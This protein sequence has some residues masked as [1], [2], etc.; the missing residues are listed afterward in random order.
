[1]GVTKDE[2]TIDDYNQ[3]FCGIITGGYRQNDISFKKTDDDS[4][5]LDIHKE[6]LFFKM[7]CTV[8][9]LV[10]H[11][12]NYN[13]NEYGTYLLH[14]NFPYTDDLISGIDGN[15]IYGVY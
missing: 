11:D 4:E 10:G 8:Y 12:L 13:K 15:E 6:S 1:M 5:I 7:N 9:D 14:L 2:Y 3:T